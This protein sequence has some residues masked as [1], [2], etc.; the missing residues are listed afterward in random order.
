MSGW[1]RISARVACTRNS[2]VLIEQI[3]KECVSLC[4]SDDRALPLAFDFSL[5]GNEAK[6]RF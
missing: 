5:F 2:L 4:L 1:S 3:E 6:N